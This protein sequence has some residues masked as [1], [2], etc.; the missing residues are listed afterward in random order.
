MFMSNSNFSTSSVST[1]DSPDVLNSLG[2]ENGDRVFLRSIATGIKTSPVWHNSQAIR[3][4][5]SAVRDSLKREEIEDKEDQEEFFSV[6]LDE[7][8]G[9]ISSILEA[10]RN[11]NALSDLEPEDRVEVMND[12][13]ELKS[14]A[15]DIHTSSKN[16]REVG[17]GTDEPPEEILESI[18]RMSRLNDEK[19]D[20]AVDPVASEDRENKVNSDFVDWATGKADFEDRFTSFNDKGKF[21][22]EMEDIWIHAHESDAPTLE[23]IRTSFDALI[24]SVEKIQDMREQWEQEMEPIGD[25]SETFADNKDETVTVGTLFRELDLDE[26]EKRSIIDQVRGK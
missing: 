23:T 6:Y 10:I 19:V 18:K 21:L 5:I 4:A 12:I 9:V 3:T 1:G 25:I 14:E 11:E 2:G 15:V 26:E 17:S 8:H 13:N 7:V 22:D 16:I 24:D 20:P